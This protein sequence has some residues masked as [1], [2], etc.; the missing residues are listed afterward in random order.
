MYRDNPTVE[1]DK[2]GPAT[3]L[4]V[5]QMHKKEHICVTRQNDAKVI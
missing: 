4:Y 3:L 2:I 1:Q 5:G